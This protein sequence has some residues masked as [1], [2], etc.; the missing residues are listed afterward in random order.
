MRKNWMLTGLVLVG[1]GVSTA[2]MSGNE[3]EELGAVQ[4]S[5]DVKL[6]QHFGEGARVQRIFGQGEEVLLGV[7]SVAVAPESDVQP[8]LG[9]ARYRPADGSLA[10]LELDQRF[11]EALQL[12]GALALIDEAGSL[13]FKDAAGT[14]I[15]LGGGVQGDLVA[16]LDAKSLLFTQVADEEAEGESAIAIT[17][18]TGARRV[19]AD[20]TGVDDRPALSPDG[21]TVVFISGRTGIASLWRTSLDGEEAVQVTNR[22]LETLVRTEEDESDPAGFVPPP[23]SHDR[24]EWVDADHIRYDAGGGTFWQVDVRSGVAQQEVSR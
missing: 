19:L 13:N 7:T 3:D 20:G 21:R 15:P 5:L 14:I 8:S 1:C 6:R 23:V 10:V 22:G 2:Q 18:L 17:D 24:L 12:G 16:T 11:R 4:H 9:L